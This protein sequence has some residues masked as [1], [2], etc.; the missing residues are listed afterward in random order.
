M[1]E[2]AVIPLMLA[3]AGGFIAGLTAS[4]T[5]QYGSTAWTIGIATG[6]V[7]AIAG[8]LSVLRAPGEQSERRMVGVLR[9]AVAVACFG[10]LYAGLIKALRDGSVVGILFILVSG[11]FAGLLTRFRVRERG[12]LRPTA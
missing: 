4:I 1:P 2:R 11:V 3:L 12:E 7:V 6:A 8:L 10:F 9:A 5:Q